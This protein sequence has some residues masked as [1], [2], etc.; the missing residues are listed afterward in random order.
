MTEATKT[1]KNLDELFNAGA[2]FGFSKSR[3]HPSNS[4]YIFGSKNRVDIFDLEKTHDKLEKALEFV[5]SL[6]ATKATILFIG[7]KN[8]AQNIVKEVAEKVG[9]PYVASRWIGGALTNFPEIR[10]RVDMMIDLLSQKE[11]GELVKYTKKER[12]LIDRKIEKLQKMFWGIKDMANLPKALFIVDPRYEITA[13][14][15]A[16][17]LNIPVIALCG[18]DNNLTE[19]DYPIPAND[20]GIASIRF[21]AEKIAEAYNTSNPKS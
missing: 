17:S 16:Q 4:P 7:G 5:A 13:L 6:A 11:K 8:E 20:S 14:K 10:K 18:S 21:F 3:R 12:V 15:E 9:M 2:H 1:D 19:V